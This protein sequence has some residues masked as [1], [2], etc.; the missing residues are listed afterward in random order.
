M[1]EFLKKYHNDNKVIVEENE[2]HALVKLYPS[3]K[4]R[5]EV[6]IPNDVYEWFV[7]FYESDTNDELWSDWSDWY[8]SGEVTKT[9]IDKY[10]Q[11]DIDC[12]MSK[13]LLAED[14]RI[15]RN[16]GFRIFGKEF[17]ISKNLFVMIDGNWIKMEVGDLPKNF[18]PN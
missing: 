1:K 12:F 6:T 17:F 16:V 8:I 5:F 14:F 2:N 13:I 11:K 10:Y 9:N 18:N 15:D 7:T 3:H 4:F